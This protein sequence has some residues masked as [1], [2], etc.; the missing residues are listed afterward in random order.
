MEAQT[1]NLDGVARALQ[2]CSEFGLDLETSGFDPKK[3]TIRGI[4]VSVGEANDETWWIPFKGEGAV[5]QVQ[6]MRALAPSLSD[7]EKTWINSHVK[8]DYEFMKMNGADI[9]T[10]LFCTVV[11]SWITNENAPSH[12][13]K[14]QV[15]REFG[16]DMMT[17]KEVMMYE[18]DLFGAGKFESYAKDDPR[19]ARKLGQLLKVRLEK[20]NLT[21]LFEAIEMPLIRVL[22]DMELTGIR[23]DLEYL[24]EL[25]KRM[26][27]E[28]QEAMQKAFA[29]VKHPFKIESPQGISKLLF[30]EMRLPIRGEMVPGKSG[31]YSTDEDTLKNYADVPVVAHI[32]EYRDAEHCL[33]TYV[34]P[35]ES[36]TKGND[37]IFASF[38]QAGTIAGRFTSSEP[39]L[40]QI[41][42]KKGSVKKMFIASPGMKL[43]CGDF[44]QLQFRL[45]G[46]FASRW[47]GKSVVAQAYHDNKDLHKKTMVDL[48]LDK[49]FD[50]PNIAR[51]RAKVVNFAF[52]FGRG[53]K[54]FAEAER[55]DIKTGKAYYE[56]FHKSYPDIRKC[57]NI[58]RKAICE[59]GYVSSLAGRRRRFPHAI[60]LDPEDYEKVGWDGWKAW[61]SLIQGSESDL[62]RLVMRDIWREIQ[63]RRKTD[64]RWANANLLVQVHDELVGE[65]PE[66]IAQDFADLMRD[67]AENAM[68][69]DVQIKMDVHIGTNWEEAKG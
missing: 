7:P 53:P 43:I 33:S 65:A 57:A 5:S 29:L 66:E 17:Y 68:K 23:I 40:Q 55:F 59:K 46:H 3:D 25:K 6:T 38:N 69:L 21:K 56:G 27:A 30:E 32:L 15:K 1:V 52:L 45:I 34:Y 31:H 48:G 51:R 20:E 47:L 16:Y 10:K 36:K 9:R 22:V 42:Q 35:Y 12:G 11:A 58:C 24:R 54:S 28:K 19:Y 61:N 2:Q 63:L 18:G 49:Q 13:L 37:R 67:K 50:D 26:E 44:N 41:P 39:N 8:F 62:V 14:E 64:S 60:G 4:G